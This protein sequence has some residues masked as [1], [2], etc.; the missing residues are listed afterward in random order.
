MTTYLFSKNEVTGLNA[1][2]TA[3]VAVIS[4]VFGTFIGVYCV[5]ESQFHFYLGV[6]LCGIFSAVTLGMGW[7]ITTIHRMR[8]AS[9]LYAWNACSMIALGL[10]LGLRS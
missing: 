3:I 9:M 6:L 7:H 5:Q 8:C 10:Y 2:L 1:R 4:I